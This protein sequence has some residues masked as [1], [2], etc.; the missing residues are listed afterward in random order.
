MSAQKTLVAVTMIVVLSCVN[1]FADGVIM[2]ADEPLMDW[3]SW[4]KYRST[5]QHPAGYINA[6]D[7]ENARGNIKRY[8]WAQEYAKGVEARAAAHRGK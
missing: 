5:V 7:L 2:P 8:E 6:R 4:E 3:S 1:G